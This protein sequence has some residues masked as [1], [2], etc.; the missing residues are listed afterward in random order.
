VHSHAGHEERVELLVRWKV[1][2][3]PWQFVLS[4]LDILK[5]PTAAA[6][7]HKGH[8]AVERMTSAQLHTVACI[9]YTCHQL[10]GPF[11]FEFVLPLFAFV[12]PLFDVLEVS[13]QQ[14]QALV[15]VKDTCLLA[16]HM[17]IIACCYF[18]PRGQQSECHMLVL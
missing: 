3:V 15:Q 2:H 17:H 14:Q 10:Q 16:L 1:S 13:Q 18:L 4:L 9:K 5:V 11:M 7:A 6:A 8:H 12:L